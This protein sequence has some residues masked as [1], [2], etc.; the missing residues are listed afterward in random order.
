MTE[1]FGLPSHILFV[2]APIAL[3]PLVVVFCAVVLLRSGLR[4]KLGWWAV[5][6]SAALMVSMFLAR[7]SGEAFEEALIAEKIISSSVI[8]QH[9]TLGNQTFL[10]SVL[11][12][13]IVTVGVVLPRRREVSKALMRGFGAATVVVGLIALVW[14]VRTGHEGA[15][16]VWGGVLP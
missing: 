10:M 3:T 5:G 15:D 2:H 6:S 7:Q 13:V 12:F 1:L 11:L 14:T 16:V 9:A 4:Q 8:E